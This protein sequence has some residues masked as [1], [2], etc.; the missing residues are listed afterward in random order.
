MLEN[1][2]LGI[3]ANFLTDFVKKLLGIASLEAPPDLGASPKTN[4]PIPPEAIQ[5]RRLYNQE[6]RDI[7]MSVISM[8]LNLSV[9]LGLS[10][11]VPFV[12][13]STAGEIDL[14]TTRTPYPHKI[15]V[16]FAVIWSF[17]FLGPPSFY[18]VQKLTQRLIQYIH[19]EWSDVSRWRAVGMFTKCCLVWF[20]LYAGIFSYW[21]F[22]KV[23]FVWAFGLPLGISILILINAYKS[24]G[25]LD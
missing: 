8:A 15:G 11:I 3:V 10:I 23:N 5:A 6:R 16:W 20:A 13:K 9:L 25:Y 19:N 1:I 21:L 12:L 14:M 17:I 18:V 7:A 2:F 4:I 22:P 24:R